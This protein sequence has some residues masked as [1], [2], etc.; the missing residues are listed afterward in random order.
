MIADSPAKDSVNATVRW[1]LTM[2]LAYLVLFDQSDEIGPSELFFVLSLLGSNLLIGRIE[3]WVGPVWSAPIQ[4]GVDS[5]LVGCGLFLADSA[6]QELVIGYFLCVLLASL[7]DSEQRLIGLSLLAAGLYAFIGARGTEDVSSSALLLRFP[8]LVLVTLSYGLLVTRLRAEQAAR[9]EAERRVAGLEGV[10]DLTRELTTTFSTE[11]ILE[12]TRRAIADALSS[13]SGRLVRTDLLDDPANSLAAEAI[14]HRRLRVREMSDGH[15]IRITVAVPIFHETEPLG[16]IVAGRSDRS[17][18]A[19]ETEF[20]QI[21]ASTAALALGSARR[22]EQLAEVE[23]TKTD[24]LR[25][26]SHEMHTPLH[27]ILG[28]SDIAQR[29][30][31]ERDL[32]GLG[33]LIQRITA[34]AQEMSTHVEHLLRLSQLTLGRERS[35]PSVVDLHEIFSRSLKGAR[36]AAAPDDVELDLKVSARLNKVIVDGEKLERIVDCLLLNAVKFGKS[37]R[38][39]IAAEMDGSSRLRLF[40]RDEGTGVPADDRRRI[41]NDFQQGD[42]SITRRFQGLGLGLAV[43]RRLVEVLGGE[44]RVASQTGRGSTFEVLLPVAIPLAA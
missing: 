23:R 16:A 41:F 27:A 44:I 7:A 14:T 43:S 31:E 17:L 28:F 25:N 11:E 2:A 1:G 35:T 3:R 4:L 38:I 12:R 19:E 40:V 30:L 36:R 20:C 8:L 22:Y 32:D 37:G 9:A 26:L 10:L 34:H 15:G 29:T 21:A 42:G 24:F 39:E 18:S 5:L 13:P 6:S 33:R